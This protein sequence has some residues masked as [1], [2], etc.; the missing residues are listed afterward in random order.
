VCVTIYSEE[1]KVKQSLSIRE[2]EKERVSVCERER[3]NVVDRLRKKKCEFF[4][5]ITEAPRV[6]DA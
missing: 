6:Y 1:Y 3:L 2:I 4:I 5:S